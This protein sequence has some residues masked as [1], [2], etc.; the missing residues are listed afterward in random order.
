MTIEPNSF[1]K[2]LNFK[3]KLSSYD[4]E[5][6]NLHTL[7]FEAIEIKEPTRLYRGDMRGEDR[8]SQGKI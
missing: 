2:Y 5:Y 4:I 3:T 8:K 6:T 7:K 1:P